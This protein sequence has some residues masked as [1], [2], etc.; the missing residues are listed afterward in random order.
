MK[1]IRITGVI[2]MYLHSCNMPIVCVVI[3]VYLKKLV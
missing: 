3:V 1:C 2:I